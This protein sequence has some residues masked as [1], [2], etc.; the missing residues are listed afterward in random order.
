M[1][2]VIT[3]V[4]EDKE[5]RTVFSVKA[6]VCADTSDDG[7]KKIVCNQEGKVKNFTF[8]K[9]FNHQT[10]KTLVCNFNLY[11]QFVIPTSRF[12]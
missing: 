7:A 8:Q 11:V 2:M 10:L 1:L 4:V 5:G 12:V 9:T 6:I 3:Q